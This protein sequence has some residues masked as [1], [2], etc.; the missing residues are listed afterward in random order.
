LFKDQH[1]ASSQ[2]RNLK[3]Y[4][5]PFNTRSSTIDLQKLVDG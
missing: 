4:A 2:V 3:F 1:K 5:H